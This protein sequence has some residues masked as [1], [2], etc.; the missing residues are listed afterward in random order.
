MEG[1]FVF[2]QWHVVE[3]GVDAPVGRVEG[4]A[5]HTRLGRLRDRLGRVLWIF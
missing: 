3:G 2:S 4:P 1:C 5:L